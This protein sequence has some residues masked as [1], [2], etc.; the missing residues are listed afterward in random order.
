MFLIFDMDKKE[1]PMFK[2]LVRRILLSVLIVWGA[3]TIVFFIL[4]ILPGDPVA[5]LLGSTATEEMVYTAREQMG[6]D[7]SLFHQYF[8]FLRQT[9]T[10]DFGHSFYFRIDTST[11]IAQRYPWT[12]Q[13]SFV[14]LT[15]ALLMGFG[16][17]LLAGLRPNTWL[18]RLINSTTL[19]L[20]NLP[21]FW[22]GLMLMR[23]FS[24]ILGILPTSGSGTPAHLILPAFSLSLGLTG[25][26]TRLV[27]TGIIE[28]MS[29]DYIRTAKAKGLTSRTV[30]SKHALKN[31]FIPIVT[32]IGLQLGALLGGA[33]VTETVFA[34]P[35]IGRLFVDAV[36]N[37]DY[38]VVQAATVLI[39]VTFVVLNL[40][41]DLIY[42]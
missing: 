39:A 12:L 37:R 25:L 32:M 18:D 13:L 4:R 26:L 8:I 33:V 6:L 35:G 24:G 17:G 7:Q 15:F 9:L 31:M 21:N 29:M 20:Q 38:S 5:L 11:L 16:L 1:N 19:I 2:Y 36:L 22:V 28:V 14:A 27:R 3:L 10:G 30:I 23:L 40:I 42:A 41:V 34:W